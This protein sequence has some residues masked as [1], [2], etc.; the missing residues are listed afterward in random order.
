MRH[1]IIMCGAPGAGKSTFIEQQG[2]R[3]F[4]ISPDE[5]RLRLGGIVMSPSGEMTVNHAHEKR[6]W[7]EVEDVLD[8]KMGQGQLVVIDATFQKPGDFTLPVRLAE[9]HMYE[10]WCVDFSGVP[11]ELALERNRL[12]EAYKVVPDQV[13]ETAYERFARH[14]MP[15]NVTRIA[16]AD[17]EGEQFLDRLEPKMRDLSSYREVMHIGDLQGCYAPV[18]ELFADGFKDD[19]YYIFIGD[20]LDRGIQNGEVIRFAMREIVP[21]DNVAFIYGNHEYHIQRFAKNLDPVSR[22]FKFNTLPQLEAVKFTRKEANALLAKADDAFTYTFRGHKMLVTHAGLSRVPDRLATLAGLQFWKGTGTYDDPVDQTFSDL[23]AGTGWM[24]VHGH[25]NSNKLPVEAAPGSFNLEAEIEFGGQLRVMSLIAGKN[26][27]EIET[28]E[29]ENKVFRKKAK[30]RRGDSISASDPGERGKVSE[31]LLTELEGHSLVRAKSFTTHPHIRSLNFTTK[32]FKSGQW[33]DVNIM[34]RGL[35]IAD[36]RAIVARSYPKFFNLEERPETQMRNL[37]N[38]LQFPL[39]MWVKENGYLGILGWDHIGDE[40]FFASKSTPESEFA[41]WFR[42]IF[43]SEAGDR[44]LSRARDIVGKRNL[45]LVFEVNDPVRD[46]HMI[47]YDTAHVVL[48]DA[49]RREEKYARLDYQELKQIAS[50]LGVRV[51]QPGPTFAQ[52]KDFEGWCKS[53][54]AQGRYYQWRNEHIEGFVAEDLAG[55]HFKIKLDFYSFWKWMRGH[56]DKIRRAREKDQPLPAPPDDDLAA[57]FHEW[58]IV[59]PDE[60]LERDII[61][62]RQEFEGQ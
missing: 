49:I 50:V 17:L 40:L 59:Q 4:T 58:L 23:M 55:F 20:L 24:Q 33:D 61:Q 53:I 26:R 54:E 45:S 39:K 29:I 38:R 37:R 9:R 7:A 10:V 56:R 42:E 15:K 22:E 16:T 41:G 51:K 2:L 31:K 19:T 14:P 13:I 48:L 11:K 47:A 34:A 5:F 35:F 27:V 30:G 12:R 57:D 52:W 25:R 62:L 43:T 46:P 44:G 60:A 32:A 1:L 18:E 8:F 28:R 36:D 6:V 21:R 3:P